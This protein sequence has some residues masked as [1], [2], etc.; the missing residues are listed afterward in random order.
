[1][2]HIA[3]PGKSRI[4]KY[5]FDGKMGNIKLQ[6]LNPSLNVDK[7]SFSS[8][9]SSGQVIEVPLRPTDYQSQ[10]TSLVVS[11]TKGSDKKSLINIIYVNPLKNTGNPNR[12]EVKEKT[13]IN[14]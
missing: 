5:E 2:I 13:I 7:E 8:A 12:F 4:I 14:F 1:M 11:V 9:K 10:L 6:T 3:Q